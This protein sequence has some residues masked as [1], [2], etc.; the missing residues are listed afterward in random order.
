MCVCVRSGKVVGV[1]TRETSED[2]L[3]DRL[4]DVSAALAR[5]EVAG[6]KS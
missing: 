5:L 3:E 4:L 1:D 2:V 6:F